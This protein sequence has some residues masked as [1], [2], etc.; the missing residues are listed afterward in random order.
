MLYLSSV[1]LTE[2]HEFLHKHIVY[3]SL[4]FPTDFFKIVFILYDVQVLKGECYNIKYNDHMTTLATITVAVLAWCPLRLD[5]R[6]FMSRPFEGSPHIY[7]RRR[8]E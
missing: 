2:F 4:D 7:K 3:K 8:N 6:L 1:F 5:S